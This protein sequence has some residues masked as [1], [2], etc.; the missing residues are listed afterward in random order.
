M[1]AFHLQLYKNKQKQNN[2]NKKKQTNTKQQHTGRDTDKNLTT[3][4]TQSNTSSTVIRAKTYQKAVHVMLF[5]EIK[6]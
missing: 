5:E 6:V 2:N 1:R 4:M 3:Q